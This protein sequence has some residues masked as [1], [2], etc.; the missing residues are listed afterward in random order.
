MCS[1]FER[2]VVFRVVFSVLDFR[3]KKKPSSFPVY[4]FVTT[5]DAALSVSWDSGYPEIRPGRKKLD[6]RKNWKAL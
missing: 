3:K 4:S 5:F 6:G 2:S 1:K